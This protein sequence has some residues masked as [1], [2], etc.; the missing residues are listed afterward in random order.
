[1]LFHF[2]GRLTEE[3]DVQISPFNRS[4]MYGDALFETM[5]ME[6]G[7]VK[8]WADHLDRISRGCEALGIKL[9]QRDWVQDISELAATFEG[10]RK[11][12][13]WQVWRK[14]G[15]LV[16]PLHEEAEW[17]ISI[18]EFTPAPLLKRKAV[19]SDVELS[20]NAY[21]CFKT[22]QF[23]PY[24]QAAIFRKQKGADEVI[25]YGPDK[26]IAEAGVGNLF[27]IKNRTVYTPSLKSGCIAGIM[28]MQIISYLKSKG[29]YIEESIFFNKDL[30]QVDAMFSCNVSGI[31]VIEEFG[32]MKYQTDNALVKELQTTFNY[33]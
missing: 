9:P 5:V 27:W 17:L 22:A 15:G 3:K 10:K 8:Y 14:D 29:I 6:N 32:F 4:F 21:S 19:I 12:I 23:M 33:F 30:M 31:S 24:I 28:R 20:Y 16:T 1:M 26:C 11:R 2:N 18:Q 13:K 7:S 25:L